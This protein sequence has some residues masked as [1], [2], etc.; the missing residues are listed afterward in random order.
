M[1]WQG[2][3]VGLALAAGGSVGGLNVRITEAPSVFDFRHTPAMRYVLELT[4]GSSEERFKVFVEPPLF[5]DG[6]SPLVLGTPGMELIGPAYSTGGVEINSS[7]VCSPARDVHHGAEP[8]RRALDVTAPPNTSTN[9]RITFD[10]SRADA[11][12]RRMKV[13][14]TIT[15]S[16]RLAASG[17]GASGTLGGELVVGPSPPRLR[18]PVGVRIVLATKPR[19]P[20]FNPRRAPT[21]RPR[22]AIRVHGRTDPVLRREILRLREIAPGTGTRLRPV[23]RVRTDNRGRFRYLWRPA[24]PGL[25]QLYAFYRRQRSGVTSDR[26]CPR[27]VRIAR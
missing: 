12:F 18:R 23:A 15:F 11:P 5:P 14:P 25:H 8:L 26:A 13:R 3:A 21:L 2:I 6:G 17:P 19:T 24:Q 27:F 4:T 10:V 22:T 7:V 16:D 1:V 9:L 20:M